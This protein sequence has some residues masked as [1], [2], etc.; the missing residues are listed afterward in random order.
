MGMENTVSSGLRVIVRQRS[1]ECVLLGIAVAL[2]LILLLLPLL[3][4]PILLLPPTGVLALVEAAAAAAAAA[5]RTIP[6]LLLLIALRG[7]NA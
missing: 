7:G 4:L 6:S 3:L 1:V 2:P 5:T